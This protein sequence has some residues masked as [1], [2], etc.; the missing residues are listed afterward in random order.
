MIKK[1]NVCL[2]SHEQVIKIKHN[3]KGDL[4]L[5]KIF[6]MLLRFFLKLTILKTKKT[7]TINKILIYCYTGIGNLILYTPALKALKEKFPSA[8][9][10]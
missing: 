6:I 4:E 9:I 8:K 5:K 3:V 7:A 2:K 10:D 1:W